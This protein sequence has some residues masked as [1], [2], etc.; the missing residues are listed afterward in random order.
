MVVDIKFNLVSYPVPD[1][2]WRYTIC[3]QFALGDV[4][5]KPNK[6]FGLRDWC[7]GSYLCPANVATEIEVFSLRAC[8]LHLTVQLFIVPWYK[9]L[10]SSKAEVSRRWAGTRCSDFYR[11]GTN[12]P[13]YWYYIVNSATSLSC[14]HTIIQ[15]S[16]L[17]IPLPV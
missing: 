9:L 16:L 11:S 1:I 5:T 14:H 8:R 10:G 4:S 12:L 6:P 17:R 2:N 7:S 3:A 13:L 15:D